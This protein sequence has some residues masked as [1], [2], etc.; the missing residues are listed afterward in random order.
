MSVSEI[1]TNG[2]QKPV[3]RRRAE[4]LLHALEELALHVEGDEDDGVLFDD[5]EEEDGVYRNGVRHDAD[6]GA[7]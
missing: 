7:D 3:R 2:T 4:Q 5:D 6:P 1:P